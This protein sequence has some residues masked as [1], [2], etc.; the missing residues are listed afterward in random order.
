MHALMHPWNEWPVTTIHH[1][2]D[3]HVANFPI[4][5]VFREFGKPPKTPSASEARMS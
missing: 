4:G 1:G 2:G 5:M 3:S